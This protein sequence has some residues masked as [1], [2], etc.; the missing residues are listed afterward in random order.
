MPSSPR[1][2]YVFSLLARFVVSSFDEFMTSFYVQLFMSFSTIQRQ[3]VLRVFT[4]GSPPIFD[5]ESISRVKEISG[6]CPVLSAFDLPTDL[7]YSYIQPWDPIVR[8]FSMYDPLYPLIDDLGERL[9]HKF[10]FDVF[11]SFFD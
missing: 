9:S 1:V 6:S 11:N 10:V 7:V 4:Y 5:I 2:V 8:L 3:R